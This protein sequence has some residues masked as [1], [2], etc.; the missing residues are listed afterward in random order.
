MNMKIINFSQE[1]QPQDDFL[2]EQEA[3]T[4]F[5]PNGKADDAIASHLAATNPHQITPNLIGAATAS[6]THTGSQVTG[7][8][9]GNAANVTGIVAIENGGTNSTT[10]SEAQFRLGVD[11]NLHTVTFQ[12]GWSEYASSEW[13]V[14][15][16]KF[17]R[18]KIING[19]V[20]RVAGNSSRHILTLPF[21]SKPENNQY[22]MS[23]VWGYWNGSYQ[24]ARVDVYPDGRIVLV[25]PNPGS[26]AIF[27]LKLHFCYI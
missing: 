3:T 18:L 15:V 24:I 13:K 12:D 21:G 26:L 27:W 25:D 6:H 1:I 16:Q 17:G 2:T 23:C 5:D 11:T 8:I 7:N 22:I 10:V 4:L 14:N 20:K 9:P 19:L